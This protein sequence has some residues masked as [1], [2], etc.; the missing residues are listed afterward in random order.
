MSNR[1]TVNQ[2]APMT[3]TS[4]RMRTLPHANISS[5]DSHD[6]FS[7]QSMYR[8]AHTTSNAMEV[9]NRDKS[10]SRKCVYTYEDKY[11]FA[12]ILV[13]DSL[14]F[15]SHFESGNLHS[16]FRILP[17]EGQ[18]GISSIYYGKQIYDL[19]M[20]PDVHTTGHTQWF[21]FSVGNTQLGAEVVF[22]LRNF[23]KPDSMFNKGMQPLM[24]SA[25]SDRKCWTRCG[26]EISYYGPIA[27]SNITEDAKKKRK[28][29]QP[30]PG[31][32]TMSFTHIFD[33]PRDTCYFAFCHPYTY[34]DLQRHL[35]ILQSSPSV[36]PLFRRAPL[37][38]TIAGNVC[39]VLTITAPCLRLSDLHQ[40][41][42]VV[43]TGRVHPGETNASW[44]MH[45]ILTFILGDSPEAQRLRTIYVFKIVPMLN[46]DGV[47][48]GN[49]RT[50][51]S[52]SDL[53]RRWCNPDKLMHPTIYHAKEM[54]RSCKAHYPQCI[55]M[56]LHGH[57]T[58]EGI[59]IYGCMPDRRL[60]RPP[61]PRRSA[62]SD[63]DPL[64]PKAPV[65]IQVGGGTVHAS[66]GSFLMPVNGLDRQPNGVY[67]PGKPQRLEENGKLIVEEPP[68]ASAPSR[69]RPPG[70]P[71]PPTELL[72]TSTANKRDLL[73]WKVKL[74]PRVLATM[75]DVFLFESCSFKVH[76]SK[77]STMRIVNFIEL[78]VDCVYTI[79]ASLAGLQPTQ[80]S[81]H[82]LVKFG[83]DVCRSLLEVYPA[84]APR[85][86]NYLNKPNW[87]PSIY[88][89]KNVIDPGVSLAHEI[90]KWREF[91]A[92]DTEG[93]GVS[94]M[95]ESAIR[96]MTVA[97]VDGEGRDDDDSD[98][99]D[100]EEKKPK[101]V[102][103]KVG[104][105][106]TG[107]EKKS[108]YSKSKDKDSDAASAV[109]EKDKKGEKNVK[110]KEKEKEKEKGGKEEKVV[111][112]NKSKK[113]VVDAEQEAA[114]LAEITAMTLFG[115]GLKQNLKL[116]DILRVDCQG[117]SLDENGFSG[118]TPDET[119]TLETVTDESV[120]VVD[121]AKQK[122]RKPKSPQKSSPRKDKE[123]EKSPTKGQRRAPGSQAIKLI[124]SR[125]SEDDPSISTPSSQQL[126]VPPGSPGGAAGGAGGAAAAA[127][128]FSPKIK[129]KTRP[130]S[131]L[132]EGAFTDKQE[133]DIG[134]GLDDFGAYLGGAMPRMRSED[135][136]LEPDADAADVDS[137]F[138]REYNATS[139]ATFLRMGPLGQ[140]LDGGAPMPLPQRSYSHGSSVPAAVPAAAAGGGGGGPQQGQG[141]GVLTSAGFASLHVG[142]KLAL[143]TGFRSSRDDLF[144]FPSS[145]SGFIKTQGGARPSSAHRSLVSPDR[146]H[147]NP[148]HPPPVSESGIMGLL[149]AKSDG[150]R[151]PIRSVKPLSPDE[152]LRTLE[153]SGL[154]LE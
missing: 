106:P 57:S 14:I 86:S 75:S 141:G 107:K 105:P 92:Y 27:N 148:K 18:G 136:N 67:I 73:D 72:P 8:A 17:A 11:T 128:E 65:P 82:D 96:E 39:D 104:K 132:S 76:R 48:N 137:D 129:K 15:D 110:K 74:F 125:S 109:E 43:I 77:A 51:L 142:A 37:C 45:G 25:A 94:L 44:M 79:E 2:V 13:A 31:M 28:K 23:A 83:F 35:R 38:K 64:L 131:K 135:W 20:H 30:A 34:T 63:I 40:R 1:C 114:I 12:R 7:L 101:V 78:G 118:L 46:P 59:F 99:E 56:D 145:P 119:V 146:K 80:F 84:F 154:D 120:S 95:S 97:A 62:S 100:E 93:L 140:G 29:G 138:L 61:S 149:N 143:G 108:V 126:N 103:E 70:P 90:E 139:A 47:I 42:L 133:L 3:G 19:Y 111:K 26:T 153:L 16:A 6:E 112:E 85:N 55:V 24:F 116:S 122:R 152:L 49:Y 147:P 68:R 89:L 50:S 87:S 52:G 5:I 113:S 98:I 36:R 9:I 115:S 117:D 134:M 69:L 130:R 10:T 71:Q 102:K 150:S 58:R 81:A 22:N 144:N 32:Y 33:R 127:G 66:S 151:S 54:I 53:N 4:T 121:T 123:A 91:S 88:C 60:L 21:Y 41:V 124:L